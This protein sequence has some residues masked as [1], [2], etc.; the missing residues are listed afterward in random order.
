MRVDHE[1]ILKRG[2]EFKTN[3]Y[4]VLSLNNGV[5]VLQMLFAI[6]PVVTG[7]LIY[8]FWRSGPIKFF[9]W[10][11]DLGLSNLLLSIRQHSYTPPSFVPNFVVYSLPN[12][13]WA[14]SFAFIVTLLWCNHKSPLKFLWLATIPV[15]GL[16]YEILQAL[17]VISGTFCFVDLGLCLAGVLTGTLLALKFKMWR[18]SHV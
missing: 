12:G 6:V 13:L 9:A 14:F 4:N 11:E 1:T 7:G 15:V 5:F 3:R 10:F 18:Q 16:G 8:L 2:K 17:E